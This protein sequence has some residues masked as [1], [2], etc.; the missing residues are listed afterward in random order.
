[1]AEDELRTEE[2]NFTPGI[3]CLLE[4]I[5][6]ESTTSSPLARLHVSLL[7]LPDEERAPKK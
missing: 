2:T 4:R 6:T 3:R 5:P 7:Q 1:M